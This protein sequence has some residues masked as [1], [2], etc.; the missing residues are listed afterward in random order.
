MKK[1]VNIFAIIFT[2]FQYLNYKM[3]RDFNRLEKAIQPTKMFLGIYTFLHLNTKNIHKI[4]P[5][6]K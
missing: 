6:A 5:K 2:Y 3:V 4:T 1:L